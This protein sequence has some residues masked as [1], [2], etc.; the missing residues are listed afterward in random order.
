MNSSYRRTPWFAL[1]LPSLASL[2]SLAS[3]VPGCTPST[4]PPPASPKSTETSSAMP[5]GRKPKLGTFGVD[6]TGLDTSTKPGKDFNAYAS[7]HWMKETQIPSDRSRWGMFDA[8]REE[9]DANVRTI[10]D[11]AKAAREKA[12][13]GS[14]TRKVADFYASYL[15]TAAL[16][17]KGL[18]PAKAALDAI[19]AAK[20]HDDVVKLMARPDL[21]TDGP[22]SAE[23]TLDEKDPDRYVVGI[24]HSGLGLPEREYYLK[25]DAQFV[26]IRAKY[27]AH[28]TKMLELSG[29]KKAA[30]S[31]KAILELETKIAEHHW[32]IADRRERDKTYNRRTVAELQK[33]APEFPWKT[34]L[35]TLGYGRETSVVVSEV[36]AV[37][38][39]AKLFKA[40]PVGTWR[41]YLSYHF[42][43]ASADVLPTAFDQEVFDFTGRT[44]NG[45]PQ[46]RDRWKRAVSAV[47]H[48]IGE[49]VGE[50][51]VSR[52]F[53]P[54]AKAEM[55]RLVENLRKGYA[56]RIQS[57]DWM[58]P[59]TKKV[60]LEKLAAFR[61]KIG[62]PSKWKNYATLEVVAGDAYGN[63][64]RAQV[65]HHEEMKNKLGKPTDRDEWFMTPQTVNAYY[66][67]V[68][69]EIV[70][71]AAI[72]QPP[73][74]DADADP[75]VNYGG[76][77][78]VIGHEMGH[79]F[80]D[81]GAKSDA[82]GVLR[83]WWGQADI[84]AFQKRTDAL[85]DQYAA[86]EPLPGIKVN[87]RL[88]L[89]ENIGDVGGLTVAHR[90][91]Q[92]SL[93]GKP[94]PTIDNYTGDQRFFLGWAQV[95][96]TIIRDQALRNQVL[97]DPHSPAMYRVNGV[98]RNLDA[99][100]TAFD[101]KEGDALYLAPS[102]RVRI[103]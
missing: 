85:A 50:I 43:R 69:N 22:I 91:Y 40:T 16:D 66:N 18:A 102:K 28:L 41:A 67:P 35:D 95:W 33:E 87:G 32:P 75:A 97:T 54:R 34:F 81:Q 17:Q 5:T 82:K 45:Q 58:T 49:A 52:F 73:F 68:F 99:W 84:D 46:Q 3:L 90:A 11:E 59:E 23:T 25:K 71:P 53:Q 56:A 96:R 24:S 103:W 101:V 39:L 31:A 94:A 4:E 86:F 42:L 76:I 21:P 29:D 74:F 30:E 65:W 27:L 61:P 20:S 19:A 78:G 72:L 44:L 14:N 6:L 26:E 70:F 80:D 48:A 60:A 8:L 1:L 15:D 88:T 12:P 100:Y 2:A 13:A 38:K 64:R 9:A 98:V 89:G 47:N 92:L 93:D 36:T 83:T 51:Y 10:L 55:D 77:G 63:A 57:V 62:Y 37:P 7:G 79:G